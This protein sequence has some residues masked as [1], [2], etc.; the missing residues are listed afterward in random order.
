MIAFLAS[1][2]GDYITGTVITVE[3]GHDVYQGR[4]PPRSL[5][6]GSGKPVA[7]QRRRSSP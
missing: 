2:A 3:G 1:P 4:Y 5:A 7:E 6:L